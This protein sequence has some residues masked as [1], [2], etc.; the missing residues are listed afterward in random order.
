MQLDEGIAVTKCSQM[1]VYGRHTENDV[2]ET[3][4]LLKKEMSNTTQSKDIFTS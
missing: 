3:E 1:L 4:V 2:V